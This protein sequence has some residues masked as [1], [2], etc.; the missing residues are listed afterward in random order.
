[1]I[2]TEDFAYPQ[3][4]ES[5]GFLLW[6]VAN[7]WQRAIKKALAPYHLTHA[8]FVLLANLHYAQLQGHELT[9]VQLAQQTQIDPMTTSTVLRTL[10]KKGLLSRVEHA[11]DTRAKTPAISPAGQALIVPAIQAV[12]A[13]DTHFFGTLK[14]ETYSGWIKTLQQIILN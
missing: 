10:Q 7:K 12:E 9:Q 8:Q 3:P 1:M 14:A 4:A 11:T 2:A 6:Q 13:F 5:P